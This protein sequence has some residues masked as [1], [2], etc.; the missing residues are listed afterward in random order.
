[1]T[2]VLPDAAR[3][4]SAD[5][6]GMIQR[7]M[8]DECYPKAA[9]PG[10]LPPED[11]IVAFLI[12]TNNLDIA[13][14]YVDRIVGRLMSSRDD[15]S[16]QTTTKPSDTTQHSK[17]SPL[18][19]MFPFANESLIVSEALISFKTSF[20]AKSTDLLY[21]SINV[22]FHYI[23]RPRIRPILTETFRDTDDIY[24]TTTTSSNT[25]PPPLAPSGTLS[26]PDEP[27][28]SSPPNATTITDVTA[29]FTRS[30]TAL[31][32]PLLRILTPA[33]A[34]RLLSIALPAVATVLEKR[35]WSL[36]ERGVSETGA[37]QLE[38]DIAGIAATAAAKGRYALRDAFAR[39]LQI[40]LV[41]CFE[42]EEWAEVLGEIDGGRKGSA[43][44]VGDGRD[45][46]EDEDGRE[47]ALERDE[48]VRARAMLRSAA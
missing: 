32:A 42:D 21:D 4:L 27:S 29:R 41:L 14:N 34:D 36:H 17:P 1:M 33:N 2:A 12:L 15:V 44:T 43:G 30:W 6:I 8:S 40:C 28:S 45:E 47:W 3:I 35:L 46:D 20:G 13:S 11:K 7:K 18:A 19:D 39:C 5:F 26:D 22:A 9:T 37:A 24:A 25:S 23:I 31:T 16:Q 38:R 48:M 10:S